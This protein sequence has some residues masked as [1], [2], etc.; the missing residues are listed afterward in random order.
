MADYD[1]KKHRDAV[2]AQL[3]LDG[4][5]RNDEPRCIH[6]GQPFRSHEST[7][8]EVGICQRCIDD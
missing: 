5:A 1:P 2:L 4:A 3:G 6:C 7:G 8:A